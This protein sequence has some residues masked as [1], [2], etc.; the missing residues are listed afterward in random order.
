MTYNDKI[1]LYKKEATYY[2]DNYYNYCE[3]LIKSGKNEDTLTEE[4]R[5]RLDTLHC[6]L[7]IENR[8]VNRLNRDIKNKLKG[9][10]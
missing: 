3:E 9:L 4:E 5:E 7:K 1:K 6:H 2:S 10:M 8:R